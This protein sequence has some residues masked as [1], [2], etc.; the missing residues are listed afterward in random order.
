MKMA[1][2]NEQDLDAAMKLVSALEAITSQWG[3][4][5]P[6]EIE[7]CGPLRETE[8]FDIDDHE[9]CRRVIEHLQ[10]LARRASLMRVVWG[11]AVMLDPANRMVDPNA[12]TI[13]HHPDCAAGLAA[14]DARRAKWAENPLPQDWQRRMIDERD[15]L[16]GRIDRLRKFI[17]SQRGASIDARERFRLG[18]QYGHMDGY[19][20]ALEARIRAFSQTPTMDDLVHPRP[21]VNRAGN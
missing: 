17:V 2:A 8:S 15:E 19:L 18:M 3:A 10:S 9:H 21:Q 14:A 5:M 13:Q 12:D 11:C 1:K 16:A 4:V 7:R 20:R 6:V